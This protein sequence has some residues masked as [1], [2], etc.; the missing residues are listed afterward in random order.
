MGMTMMNDD[1]EVTYVR[2][3]V[4][5]FCQRRKADSST[6]SRWRSRECLQISIC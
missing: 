4:S 6:L 3:F 5:Q 1:K 2:S